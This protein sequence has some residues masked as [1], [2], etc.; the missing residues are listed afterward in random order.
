[1]WNL[2]CAYIKT[3]YSTVVPM[4]HQ[5]EQGASHESEDDCRIRAAAVLVWPKGGIQGIHHSAWGD[6]I[7]ILSSWLL[8]ETFKQ[9]YSF[10]MQFESM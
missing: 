3:I 8:V 10:L 2:N 5:C 1:L 4:S 6:M 9:Y 7:N